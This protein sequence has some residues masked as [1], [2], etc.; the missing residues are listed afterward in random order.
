MLRKYRDMGLDV[1]D[2]IMTII[3]KE[4]DRE[5]SYEEVVSFLQDQADIFSL[6]L[7]DELS[8]SSNSKVKK[9]ATKWQTV[10]KQIVHATPAVFI[11]RVWG[12]ALGLNYESYE[13]ECLFCDL[14][15]YLIYETLFQNGYVSGNLHQI[16][17]PTAKDE[18]RDIQL[19]VY[20]RAFEIGKQIKSLEE[21]I[22]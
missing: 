5:L 11:A 7:I 15:G 10:Y 4:T 13:E 12:L 18:R 16:T 3:E 21:V 20:Q 9:L 19:K 14:I 8:N 22:R 2:I 17:P 6:E 1:Q